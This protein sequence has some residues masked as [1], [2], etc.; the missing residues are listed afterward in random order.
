MNTDVTEMRAQGGFLTTCFMGERSF[1]AG[2]LCPSLASGW[3]S[4][5]PGREKV[6]FQMGKREHS[7]VDHKPFSSV[8]TD[9]SLAPVQKRCLNQTQKKAEL[10]IVVGFLLFPEVHVPSQGLCWLK[11]SFLFRGLG[12]SGGR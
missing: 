8:N 6:K 2:A 4:A 1:Q 5:C 12:G 9:F 3:F 10:R 11:C 7:V